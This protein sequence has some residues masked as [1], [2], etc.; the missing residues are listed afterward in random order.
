MIHTGTAR[1]VNGRIK[2]FDIKI[3][4]FAEINILKIISLYEKQTL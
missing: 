2:C 1:V 3:V 4:L